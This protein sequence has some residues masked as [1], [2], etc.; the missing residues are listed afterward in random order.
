[1]QAKLLN[2]INENIT[3]IAASERVTKDTLSVLS[4]DLLEYIVLNGSNDIGTVNR[5][6]D[7][8]TPMNQNAAVL[9]FN[10][11]LPFQQDDQGVAFGVKTKDKKQLAK[12]QERVETFMADPLNDIWTWAI[13]NIEMKPR[14]A[15]A[16]RIGAVVKQALAGIEDTDEREG[17]EAISPSDVIKAIMVAGVTLDDVWAA[18][19]DGVKPGS[20]GAMPVDGPIAANDNNSQI[21]N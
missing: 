10:H 6:L 5:L 13:R 21:L 11:F 2:T 17:L 3:I 8:L 7:V 1:M 12:Y 19:D 16:D 18:I 20:V 15:F 14:Q 9:F 4:R